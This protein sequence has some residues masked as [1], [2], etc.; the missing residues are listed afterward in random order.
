M[1]LGGAAQVAAA[2]CP[3]EWTLNPAV[4]I[5]TERFTVCGLHPTCSL[6]SQLGGLGECCKLLAA[7]GAEPWPKTGFDAFGAS[8]NTSDGDKF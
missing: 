7:L 8:N 5:Q 2:H 6:V 3:N 1:T 4:C